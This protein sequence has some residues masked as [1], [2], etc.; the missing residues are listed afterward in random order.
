MLKIVVEMTEKSTM[1][2]SKKNLSCVLNICFALAI[3]RNLEDLN[4]HS[5][6]IATNLDRIMF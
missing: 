6:M 5:I 2:T 1:Q 4:L 3:D